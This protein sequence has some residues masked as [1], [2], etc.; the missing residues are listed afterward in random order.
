MVLRGKKIISIL[1]IYFPSDHPTQAPT[2]WDLGRL[3]PPK[4]TF[5]GTEPPPNILFNNFTKKNYLSFIF[6]DIIILYGFINS[7]V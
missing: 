7:I 2:P 6:N 4:T 5:G 1:N 3:K